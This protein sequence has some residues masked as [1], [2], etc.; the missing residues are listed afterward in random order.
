MARSAEAAGADALVVAEARADPGTRTRSAPRPAPSSR[1]PIVEAS[2]RRD[3]RP[4]ASTI[5]AADV[6][7]PRPA[8]PTPT[9]R[10]P[11]AIVVGA[12]DAGLGARWLAAADVQVSIPVAARQRRQPER[13]DRR[14]DPPLRGGAPA[15]LTATTSSARAPIVEQPPRSHADALA[16][17][18]SARAS[19]ASSSS[20]PARSSRAARST[21][22]RSLTDEEKRRGVI[23]ISAGN[24]AQAVAFAAAEYGVD[25]LDRDVGRRLR[26]EDRG[27]ARLRR[28]GRPRGD[29]RRPR[30]S[31][32][33]ARADRADRPHV[34]PPV[35]RPGRPRRRRHGRRSRSRRTRPTPTPSIVPVGGGGLI[36]G[37]RR[38][39]RRD[40]PI[41]VIAGRAG[42]EPGARTR[43][44]RPGEP[45]RGRRRPRSPTGSTPRSIG[46]SALELCRDLER[47]LV[48]EEEI[49]DAFR[50]LYER[51]KLACEPAGAVAAA[52]ILA[53][54]GRRRAPGRHCQ[55]R[56]RRAPKPPL[57]SWASR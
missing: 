56:Q 6:D 30:R 4:S 17:A 42:D 20:A 7:A 40:G 2:A 53:G 19:S 3:R 14:R 36:A 33:L 28:H 39:A 18:R 45:V 10:G 25:A 54:Q 48:T 37:H 9:S 26:A 21:S 8:T 12:E 49:E 44:S 15:W 29:D 24:H 34:R 1:C 52:A 11:T 41:R 5:V 46:R 27:D 31:T 55:R 50:F 35:R 47:V 13:R 57:V 43:R 22:S 38:R 32:R 51:A 16:R 23:A